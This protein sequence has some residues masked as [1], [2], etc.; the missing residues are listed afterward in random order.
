MSTELNKLLVVGTSLHVQPRHKEDV[1]C[2]DSRAGLAKWL[3]VLGSFNHCIIEASRTWGSPGS[4]SAHLLQKRQLVLTEECTG[5]TR[6]KAGRER[7]RERENSEEQTPNCPETRWIFAGFT[8]RSMDLYLLRPSSGCGGSSFLVG[9][10]NSFCT[11][12]R[13]T[14]PN[15]S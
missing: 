8:V 7:E 1:D 6:I 13:V 9:F 2:F 4:Q 14:R 5:E 10:P 15:F 11:P 12:S 3:D